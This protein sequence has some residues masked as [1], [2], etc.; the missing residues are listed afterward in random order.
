MGDWNFLGGIL[1]EVHIHS[2]IIGKIWLTILFV[3]RML[4]LGVATEDVWND[5]QS[6]FIC[7]TEQPGCR[8]VCYDEAFP[9]SL[10][11]YWVLQVIFVSSPSLVYMGHA[12]YR[13]RALEKERQKKKAQVRVELEST[14]LEM[15]ENRKRLERELRQLDQRKLNKAPLRGSLLC[16]YV[17]HI[18]TRS[19]VEVGFMIGQYL[20]YGFHLDPLYKCQR[21]PCPNTVDCFVSRPTEKTVFIL[22][23]QSIATVSLLLNILEIIHLGFRK[24]K[25]GLCGQNKDKNDPDNFYVNKSKKYSVIPHSSLGI[26][27][28][29]QKTL[30]SALSSYTFL[31]EKQT[32]TDLYPVLNSRMFQSVQNNMESSSNYT[33]RNQE[34][35]WPKKRPATNALD[36]Q[37]QNTSTNNN[38]GLLGE[39]GTEAHDEEKET[40]KKY[41]RAVTQNADNALSTC[42]RIFAE[43]PSQTSLQP[44]RTVPIISFRRQHGISSSWN[45]SAMVESAGASTNS[46]PTNSNRR[47]SSFSA[48]KAQPPYNAD[49]KN[50]NQPDTPD[51]TGEVSSESKQSRNCD[52]PKPF[53]LSRQLSLSSNASNRRAPTDLQ[54]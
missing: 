48:N 12:L 27:T 42:L 46:L 18:F 3:F 29:S 1:E 38:E 24:I 21:D 23:M 20:L 54:I 13:L 2:T 52:S 8:N 53:S 34:N 15:T 32:D 36:S 30:P 43:M 22:F 19:A 31:T 49:V 50:S 35:K 6:E 28:T 16:T 41:F 7:N 4:V 33:H 26:S 44:D 51:S 11:R 45:C 25:M 9:I 14:E 40:E 39:L 47:Q 37:T 10:I 5:E 17:I